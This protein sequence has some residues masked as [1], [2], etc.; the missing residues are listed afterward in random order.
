MKTA[1]ILLVAGLLAASSASAKIM[2]D[3]VLV[4]DAGNAGEI[5]S[6]GTFGAVSYDYYIGTYEVTNAQYA[7][8]LNAVAA[9]D[10]HSLWKDDMSSDDRGGIVRS[11]SPG[12][13]TYSTKANFDN[14]P[15]NYVSF[16][17][18]ARFANWL[19]NGQPTGAQ[20]S[21]TTE[22]G[23]YDLGGVTT[24]W[25]GSFPRQ[26]DFSSGQNGVAIASEDEWYKAAFF[27]GANS[28]SGAA[29][30]P[31]GE[32][33]WLYTTQ[34]N[35]APTKA[36]YSPNGDISNPG[37]NVANYSYTN[38][39]W[40][41]PGQVTTV[42]SAGAGSASYYG[43]FD[44]GGNVREWNDPALS[45]IGIVIRGGGFSGGPGSLQGDGRDGNTGPT[46]SPS[47]GFRVTSLA[48]IGSSGPSFARPVGWHW[49]EGE[50]EWSDA[51]QY[52]YW[53]PA[54]P[55]F[56]QNTASGEVVPRPVN[57][58]NFYNWPYFYNADEGVWYF[59]FQGNLPYVFNPETGEW[60]RWGE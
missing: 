17:D 23:M 12:N 59:I 33:Y 54:G 48:P 18:A 30:T 15:V 46:E 50:W 56:V 21:G 3:T 57:G 26:I 52:W 13:F 22:D 44:Q 43:T 9:M 51:G 27:S 28:G 60:R 29:T 38:F 41:E 24:P 31:N 45:T 34:S 49:T 53:I 36:T 16:W 7:A 4:G 39:P 40:L 20:G 55:P 35:T 47:I 5:Q 32:G 25:I 2:I 58:W 6:E 14:K 1:S 42:G 11:G 37:T 10:T 19:T 8:F